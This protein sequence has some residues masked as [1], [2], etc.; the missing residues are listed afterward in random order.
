MPDEEN[1]LT[2]IMQILRKLPLCPMVMVIIFIWKNIGYN[3]ALF[4]SGLSSIPEEYYECADVEGAGRF[5]KVMISTRNVVGAR[6]T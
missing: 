3:M 2:L 4:I 6:Y 1:F 5:W